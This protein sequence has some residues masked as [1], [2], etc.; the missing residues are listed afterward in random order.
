M[1]RGGG[2]VACVGVGLEG[3][4]GWCVGAVWGGGW[5][6]TQPPP[7]APGTTRKRTIR[8]GAVG[9][10]PTTGNSNYIFGA[11]PTVQQSMIRLVL[12]AIYRYTIQLSQPGGSTQTISTAIITAT[13]MLIVAILI[14]QRP[15]QPS[16]CLI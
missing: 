8:A 10:A 11:A 7:F 6:W 4:G 9:Q 15:K 2:V 5:W 16:A 14:Q 1:V 12:E 3:G 13:V